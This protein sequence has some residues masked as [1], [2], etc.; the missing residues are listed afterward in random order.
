[1]REKEQEFI[2]SSRLN[3][4]ALLVGIRAKNN[5][6][7][8]AV[9]L[10]TDKLQGDYMDLKT[11]LLEK[12]FTELAGENYNLPPLHLHK[13]AIFID[14]VIEIVSQNEPRVSGVACGHCADCKYFLDLNTPYLNFCCDH[15]NLKIE[16]AIPDRKTFGCSYYKSKPSR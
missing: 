7:R 14:D 8:V 2:Y 5:Y 15:P 1:V 12:S 3:G 10:P 11:K 16:M 9:V 4:L 13:P 6:N